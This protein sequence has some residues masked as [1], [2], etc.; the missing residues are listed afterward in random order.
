MLSLA[1][2]LVVNREPE[3]VAAADAGNSA[4]AARGAVHPVLGDRG[5]FRSLKSCVD[6]IPFIQPEKGEKT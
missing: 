2:K 1:P 5:A 4:S 6:L 3:L